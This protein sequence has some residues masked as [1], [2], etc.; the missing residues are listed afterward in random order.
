MF[1]LLKPLI[2]QMYPAGQVVGL[3]V[4]PTPPGQICPIGHSI[5][6]TYF[7]LS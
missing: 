3:T 1:G 4:N 7:A 6:L 2:E 5:H